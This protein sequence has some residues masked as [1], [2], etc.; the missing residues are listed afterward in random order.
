MIQNGVIITLLDWIAVE[1]RMIKI[2]HG[3]YD[4]DWDGLVWS[5]NSTIMPKDSPVCGWDNKLCE[6]KDNNGLLIGLLTSAA[7][8]LVTILALLL[9]VMNKYRY[10]E[11]LKM[12]REVMI[13]VQNIHSIEQH[14]YVETEEATGS[15]PY[16]IVLYNGDEV[17]KYPLPAAEIDIYNSSM[18]SELKIMKELKFENVNTF[19]G[20][21][22][23]MSNVCVLMEYPSRKSLAEILRGYA[24]LDWGLKVSVIND[25]ACGMAYIH[26][27]VL[28]CHGRL[29]S[30]TCFV[31]S[32]WTCK[33]SGH[34]FLSLRFPL[35]DLGPEE[36]IWTAPELLR[37]TLAFNEH[38]IRKGDVYSFSLVASEVILQNVPF[39][40][41]KLEAHQ[42]IDMVKQVMGPPLRPFIPSDQCQPE[43]K[44]LIATCWNEDPESRP[45]FSEI[46]GCIF[47]INGGK[48][49]S[50]TD[51][52]IKRLE[53]YTQKLEERVEDQAR[54]FEE[55]KYKVQMILCE[56]LPK[57]IAEQLAFGYRVGPEAFDCV[58]IFF[59]DIVGFTHISAQS[60]PLEIVNM[61]NSMYTLFDDI[62]Q[63]FDVY[64]IATIGDAYMVASGVPIRNGDKHAAEISCMS[65][66]LLKVINAFPISHLADEFVELRIGLHSG[67]C[68]A[69]VTG[70]KM[71]RY[72]LFGDTVDI[73]A[74]MESS[75][76]P[77]AI[78]I[79]ATTAQLI[80]NF[81]DIFV[82]ESSSAI[83]FMDKGVINTFWLSSKVSE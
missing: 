17:V 31:D 56:L 70:L 2:Y 61:L 82:I 20:I 39:A 41:E 22:N 48:T 28:G 54:E 78:H 65:L 38:N 64:K 76:R 21:C 6:Q 9:V 58:T 36:L 32:R 50:V 26:Q 37:N 35:Y 67:A 7:L 25:I 15:C 62:A 34:G 68:V 43:W 51:S 49:V 40:A 46:L 59:S 60:T 44:Y 8:L 71:P 5:G 12:V 27:S 55:E 23:D 45:P 66:A 57:S 81:D 42:I 14:D 80:K 72:L 11:T 74:R 30:T 69:G 18:L 4:D 73:A 10:Q 75:G 1:N 16:T 83:D 77:M 29:T 63:Q 79:S 47:R 24:K 3:E 53:V 19:I 33:V 52:L 13:S